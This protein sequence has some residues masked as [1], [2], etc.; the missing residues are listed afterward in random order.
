VFN[1][2]GNLEY[3]DMPST[4]AQPWSCPYSATTGD[5]T[6]LDV[7]LSA[8]NAGAGAIGDCGCIPNPGYV[9]NVELFIPQ[10]FSGALPTPT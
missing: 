8:Y 5:S 4:T 1:D 3:P 7:T 6:L 2:P 10:F 9:A